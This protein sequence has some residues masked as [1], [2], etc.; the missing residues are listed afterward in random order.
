LQRAANY[1]NRR[2]KMKIKEPV[3]SGLR[4][5][6]WAG[7]PKRKIPA[8]PPHPL[9]GIS[10]ERQKILKRRELYRTAPYK[11]RNNYAP[12]RR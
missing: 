11:W 6:Y 5:P 1:N 12:K 8:R 9:S 3:K 4:H 10:E 2:R 7:F